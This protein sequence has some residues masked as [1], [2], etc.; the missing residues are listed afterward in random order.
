ME[1]TVVL[2]GKPGRFVAGLGWI[3]PSRFLT[4]GRAAESFWAELSGLFC[5]RLELAGA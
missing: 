4:L 3:R 5:A 2:R 1:K